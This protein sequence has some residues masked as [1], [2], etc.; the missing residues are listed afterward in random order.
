M[1]R[2]LIFLIIPY[3]LTNTTFL[4]K[5][6]YAKAETSTYAKAMSNCVLYKSQSLE[7]KA[8]NIY[9][10]IPETYF[11]IILD[12]L[13]D[14][15]YKVQ[16]D[17]FIGFADPS[18][19]IIATFIPIV[20]TLENITLDIKDT[21]GT[22]IWN[23]PNTEGTILTTIS[24]GFKNIQYIASCYGSIPIGGESNL[25]YY[26]NYTPS[27]NSTNVYEGYIYSENTTNLSEIILNTESNPEI[28][29]DNILGD[30]VLYLSSSLKSVIIVIIT[31]PIIIFLLIILYKSTKKFNDFTNKHKKE[32]D[33][34]IN[35]NENNSINSSN[36][37]FYQ[38]N[39]LSENN[40][41]SVN[42]NPLKTKLSS[43]K[44]LKLI[45]KSNSLNNQQ[46][47]YP[48]FPTYNPDDDIL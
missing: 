43:L 41:K 16:Y 35:F 33:H 14:N 34:P 12:K 7:N 17:K 39:H 6:T 4:N 10:I 38:N 1:K 29:E 13:S 42:E 5:N 25:W 2:F 31:I 46:S 47:N 40:H 19:L 24:A 18:T 28:I 45:K 48:S 27:A 9:F 26:I 8:S 30:N 44:N 11:V 32:N 15:C 22:Q 37:S 36:H 23:M 20:K 3:C 21:S